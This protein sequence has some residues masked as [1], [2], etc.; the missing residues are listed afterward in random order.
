MQLHVNTKPHWNLVMLA[1]SSNALPN[2]FL[3][4]HEIFRHYDVHSTV[5]NIQFATLCYNTCSMLWGNSYIHQPVKHY[6]WN[7]IFLVKML[8]HVLQDITSNNKQEKH[9]R[10]FIVPILIFSTYLHSVN[11]IVNGL[12]AVALM[13]CCNFLSHVGCMRCWGNKG[14]LKLIIA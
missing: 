7:F 4:N 3:E 2:S 8:S 1:L 12:L 9:L 14:E 5:A 10:L 13:L 6:A 11:E